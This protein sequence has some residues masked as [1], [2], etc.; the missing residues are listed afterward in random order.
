MNYEDLVFEGKLK[1][2]SGI[3]F[4]QIERLM[5]RARADLD[6]AKKLIKEDNAVA[7]SIVYKAMF[8]AG[9]ALVRVQGF[10]PG[11][12]K[13]HIGIIEA[14]RRTLGDDAKTL[15]I[16]FDILRKTRNKFEYQAIFDMSESQIEK[17]LDDAKE[18][19]FKIGRY[20]QEKNPQ[21]RLDI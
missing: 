6:T 16:K 10:R 15:I 2:E 17:G 5:S 8:H 20:I 3:G 4:D 11:A 7:L 18:L 21:Q 9:N 12:K 19:V 13:Q 14:V 1:E